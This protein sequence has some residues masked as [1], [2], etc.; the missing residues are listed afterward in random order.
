MSRYFHLS[1]GLRGCYMPDNSQIV[2][3]TTRREL[4][5]HVAELVAMLDYPFGGSKAAI[6]EVVAMAWR[7]DRKEWHDFVVPLSSERGVYRFGVFIS[8]STRADYLA[9]GGDE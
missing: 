8:N 7:S 1:S 9:Q 4:K 3:V 6:A 5:E 2:K